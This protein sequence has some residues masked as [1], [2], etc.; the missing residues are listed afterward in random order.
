[1]GKERES[2][3]QGN[4]EKMLDAKRVRETHTRRQFVAGGKGKVAK[5]SQNFSRAET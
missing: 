2:L 3:F 4:K 5:T 1:M